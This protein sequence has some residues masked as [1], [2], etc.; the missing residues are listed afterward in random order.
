MKLPWL[1]C[2]VDYEHL[3]YEP[4]QPGGA[5][6]SK[7][8][9]N[10]SC[11]KDINQ[12]SFVEI[13]CPIHKEHIEKKGAELESLGLL[14]RFH[15]NQLAVRCECFIYNDFNGILTVVF[16]ICTFFPMEKENQI[17]EK[18]NNTPTDFTRGKK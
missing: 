13:T 5:G 16:K 9:F 18:S 15:Q 6:K 1:D 17:V 11:T 4:E 2:I 14:D 3:Y 12:G 8:Y 7:F 10:F